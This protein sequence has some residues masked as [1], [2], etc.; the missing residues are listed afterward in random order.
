MA[1]TRPTIQ[2]INTNLT[3]FTDSLTVTNFGNIANRDIGE[4]FDRSQGGGSNV[5]SFWQE[6]TQSFAYAYTSSTGLAAGNLVVTSYAN[7][8]LN[9]ITAANITAG[10]LIVSN[11]VYQNAEYVTTTE[12]VAGNITSNGLTVNSSATIG[13]TLGVTGNIIAGNITTGQLVATNFIGNGAGLSG[14]YGNATVASYLPT[15]SGNLGGTLTTAAQPYVTSLGTLTGLTLS[16]TMIGTA[17]N[18]A[19]FGN[20]GA[21]FTG[22]I[23]S[24]G[25]ASIS[26]NLTVSGTTNLGDASKV[27]I[28]GGANNN[29]LKT[30]GS[31]NISWGAA[32]SGIAFTT[33][34][35]P[36]VSGNIAGDQWYNTTT[37]VLYE[38]QNVGGTY[39][40]V[41]IASPTVQSGNTVSLTNTI[42]TGNL[43]PGVTS[44]YTLGNASYRFAS[45]NISGNI[46]AGNIIAT[47]F[48]NSSGTTATYT[49]NVTVGNL[50]VSGNIVSN[51]SGYFPGPFDESTALSGVFVGNAGSPGGQTPRIAFFNGNTSQNWEIDNYGGQFRWFVPGATRMVLDPNGNLTVSP[52]NVIVSGNVT[53][54]GIAPFYAPNRPAFR[55]T[56]NGGTIFGNTVVAGGYM[57][58]DYNQGGYLNTSTGY[59]T[60]P[61]AGLYQINL[62]TRTSTNSNSGIIQSIIQKTSSGV[63]TTMIMVEYG[64][65][66]SMNHTGGSTVAKLAV[67]DTL[68]FNVAV[69]NISFDGNDNWSVSYL[70]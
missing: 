46:N 47:H 4:V 8:T 24:I 50:T 13:S 36:P 61:V 6:S 66:T 53:A 5:A 15:Y 63:T 48:G 52:G 62:T 25:A 56:G 57:V 55:I 43:I 37:D 7:L 17:I 49:G 30:D 39:F 29:V 33:N 40:W 69:G 35:A 67:G 64:P 34:T 2:N 65:N 31:G 21:N 3:A 28:T 41:D 22:N 18:A 58:V 23:F 42:I 68:R 38:W 70:G 14:L 54:S 12:T 32:G 60:A 1:L 10:N 51:G 27:V 9:N 20:N 16:G 44:V 59:F 11:V 45:A 19:T 26:N